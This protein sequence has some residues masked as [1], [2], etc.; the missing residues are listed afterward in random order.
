MILPEKFL[1]E[2]KSRGSPGT[3]SVSFM[4]N[5]DAAFIREMRQTANRGLAIF[6]VSEFARLSGNPDLL[7]GEATTDI[8][9]LEEL[10][11]DIQLCTWRAAIGPSRLC[12]MQVNGP[13]GRATVETLSRS[14][15]ECL[16]LWSQRGDMAWAF[17]RWPEGLVLRASA[18][19][20]APGVRILG[21]GDSCPAP[22]S[23]GCAW[24]N[25]WAE[26]EAV[27]YWLR[28]L[29][30]ET[31]DCPPEKAAPVPK[32]SPQP[33]RCRSIKHLE[34]PRHSL[35]RRHPTCDQAG[36]RGGYR[37]SDRR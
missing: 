19:R 37:I 34:R 23:G 10:A 16:T 8:H 4:E 26:I 3:A 18:K 11:L 32:P 7:I 21:P 25:P 14:Q 33:S 36:W 29:A 1:T 22:P 15:G 17:F 30:F 6:P 24:S 35:H 28:E 20:A 27:P 9:R 2:R 13:L 12:V 5:R 31:P